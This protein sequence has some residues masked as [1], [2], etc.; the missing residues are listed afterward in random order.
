MSEAKED[1]SF[2]DTIA[3]MSSGI[4]AGLGVVGLVIGLIMS[5][6]SPETED[7]YEFVDIGNLICVTINGQ[8]V[9]CDW[10][11]FRR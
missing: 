5:C 6:S 7:K 10:S 1:R 11:N 2:G 9:S 8:F 3:G 4:I